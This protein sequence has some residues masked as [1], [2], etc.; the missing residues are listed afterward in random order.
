MDKSVKGVPTRL[1]GWD[2]D[3]SRFRGNEL[4]IID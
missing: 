4:E 3:I 1:M 2:L